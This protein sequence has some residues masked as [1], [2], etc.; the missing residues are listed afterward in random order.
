MLCEG[1]ELAP[2]AP[3]RTRRSNREICFSPHEIDIRGLCH[4]LQLNLGQ[5]K[6]ESRGTMAG[7]GLLT[8]GLNIAGV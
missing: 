5:E 8:L 4:D 1:N 3:V 7:S 6:A 2:C